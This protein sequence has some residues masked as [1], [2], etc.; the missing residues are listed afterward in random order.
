MDYEITEYKE[1]FREVFAGLLADLDR[2]LKKQ[3]IKD[4]DHPLFV[5]RNQVNDIWLD[6]LGATYNSMEDMIKLR[7]QYEFLQA[8]VGQLNK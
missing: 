4:E 3:H 2:Y 8:Y 1:I 6:I 5:L 7:G